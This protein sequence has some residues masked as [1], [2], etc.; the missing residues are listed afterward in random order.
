MDKMAMITTKRNIDLVNAFFFKEL[1]NTS[2]GV[3]LF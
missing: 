3:D 2:K 1:K